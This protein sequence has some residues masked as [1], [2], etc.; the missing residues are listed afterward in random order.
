MFEYTE[1]M[2]GQ[3][4]RQIIDGGVILFTTESG[5]VEYDERERPID[6]EHCVSTLNFT[7]FTHKQNQAK[8]LLGVYD[9]DVYKAF[10]RVMVE[11]KIMLELL[12]AWDDFD[13]QEPLVYDS[14]QDYRNHKH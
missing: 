5:Q 3:H 8:A 2:L 1:K 11:R 13:N 6:L 9:T 14:Y 12:E 10:Y 4:V 7:G